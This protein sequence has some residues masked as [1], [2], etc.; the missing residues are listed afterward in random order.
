MDDTDAKLE[1]G[2]QSDVWRYLE[3]TPCPECHGSGS[4]TLLVTARP[5]GTCEGSGKVQGEAVHEHTPPQLGYYRRK[6]SFNEQG[7]LATVSQ[8]FEPAPG[9][10]EI[11]SPKPET[12]NK[13]KWRKRKMTQVR[14]EDT[15]RF[16]NGPRREA[17]IASVS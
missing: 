4:I 17:A 7:R 11:R 5:C 2:P 6:C 8:W 12:R 9:K 1:L 13:F 3:A 14:K 15:A 16:D 10:F